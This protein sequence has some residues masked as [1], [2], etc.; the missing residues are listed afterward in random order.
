[1]QRCTHVDGIGDVL[2]TRFI[3]AGAA[4][5]VTD[6]GMCDVSELPA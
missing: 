1:M 2:T 4:G 5:V 3:D 6:G